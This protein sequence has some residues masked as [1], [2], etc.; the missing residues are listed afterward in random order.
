MCT[1]FSGN[2]IQSERLWMELLMRLPREEWFCNSDRFG[3]LFCCCLSTVHA[4]SF[5]S[6]GMIIHRSTDVRFISIRYEYKHIRNFLTPTQHPPSLNTRRLSFRRT[7]T[8][9]ESPS[10]SHPPSS[11]YQPNIYWP[12]T[13]TTQ[14]NNIHKHTHTHQPK[15]PTISIYQLWT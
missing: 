9:S 11:L 14:T 2:P 6:Q 7:T 8:T 1:I 15:T 5:G 12:Y 4:S 10:Q 13:T 3:L